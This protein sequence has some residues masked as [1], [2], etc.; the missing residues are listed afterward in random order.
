MLDSQAG[1]SLSSRPGRFANSPLLSRIVTLLGNLLR[2]TKIRLLLASIVVFVLWLIL[3]NREFYRFLS[4][5]F[6]L[7]SNVLCSCGGSVPA[8]IMGLRVQ[9]GINRAY[10]SRR[11][12]DELERPARMGDREKQYGQ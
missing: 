7:I 9:R 2:K 10:E 3:A 8:V 11:R 6:Q 1:T 4:V 5:N 12:C